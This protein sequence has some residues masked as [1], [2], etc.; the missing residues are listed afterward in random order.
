MRK[1][2]VVWRSEYVRGGRG[3]RKNPMF[4]MRRRGRKIET[5]MCLFL[6]EVLLF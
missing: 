3:R 5:R 2:C 6:F 4:F 1:Y